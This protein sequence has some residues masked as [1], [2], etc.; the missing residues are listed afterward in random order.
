M[1]TDMT[2]RTAGF[3]ESAA[4]LLLLLSR[5]HRPCLNRWDHQAFAATGLNLLFGDC[6]EA[7]DVA[8]AVETATRQE[9][10]Q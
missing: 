10:I 6:I 5:Q 2:P 1:T 9:G 3:I 7:E 8:A 4:T